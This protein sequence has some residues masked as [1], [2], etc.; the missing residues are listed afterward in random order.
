L[1]ANG[2]D[3]AVA[4]IDLGVGRFAGLTPTGCCPGAVLLSADGGTLYVANTKGVGGRDVRRAEGF[5]SHDHLGSV[6]FI[7]VPD[8]GLLEDYIIRAATNMQLP[9]IWQTMNPQRVEER[10][11]PVPHVRGSRRSSSMCCTSSRRIA[12]TTR[13][14][15]ISRRATTT[16][17]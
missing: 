13:S 10:I 1:V 8:A 16:R 17:S 7:D 4:V 5:N 14:S 9:R 2:G 3:N 6:S 11:V 12:P 15:A